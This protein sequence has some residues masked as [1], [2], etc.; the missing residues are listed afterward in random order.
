MGWEVPSERL[1]R[2]KEKGTLPASRVTFMGLL[3]TLKQGFQRALE[4]RWNEKCSG[5]RCQRSREQVG[6]ESGR[7][8]N[9]TC[10]QARP[11]PQACAISNAVW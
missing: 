8:G 7:R 9:T 6:G 1:R 10:T 11:S 3:L 4:R 5:S 2:K